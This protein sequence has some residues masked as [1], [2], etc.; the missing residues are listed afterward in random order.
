MFMLKNVRVN[1]PNLFKKSKFDKYGATLMLEPDSEQYKTVKHEIDRVTKESFKGKKLPADKVCLKDGDDTGKDV[2]A[3]LYVLNTNSNTPPH[4]ISHINPKEKVAEDEN[5]IYSGCYVNVKVNLWAQDNE[6]GKRINAELI[7]IQFAKNGE[8]LS[9]TH[10]SEDEAVD[11]FDAV[12]ED[13]E[14][15]AA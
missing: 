6:W 1:F 11:G 15:W 13:D 7:A 8:P 4:V 10:V 14:D 2:Y 3:G 12:E 9:G 5:K